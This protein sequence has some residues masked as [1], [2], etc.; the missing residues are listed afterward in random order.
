[1]EVTLSKFSQKNLPAIHNFYTNCVEWK[2]WDAPWEDWSYNEDYELSKRLERT[3][4]TPCF[5][6]E[7]F[8]NKKH[9]GWVS[10]YYMTDDYKWNDLEKTDKIAIGI[11]IP[12]QKYRHL[13]IGK[14]VYKEYLS[15]FKSLEY[16]EIYTQT[17]SGNIP[18][19]NLAKSLGFEEVN[20][21]KDLRT[22]R[23]KKYDALTFKIIL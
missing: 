14:H 1:M 3:N 13:G 4:H 22:V 6:Y 23:D 10:A 11:V 17:W 19:I 9:I 12:E 7:I 15:Y 21:F 5:E 8:Y 16:K 2:L 20:R 18:M